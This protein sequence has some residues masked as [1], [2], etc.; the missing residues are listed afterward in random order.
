[1]TEKHFTAVVFDFDGTLLDTLAD[2]SASVNHALS[3]QGL[4]PRT[5]DEV[6]VALGYGYR[7]L[8]EHCVPENTPENV[9]NDTLKIFSE[10]YYNH[11]L[12]YTCPY[13]GIPETLKEL[14]RKGYKMGIVSN[15]NMAAVKELA[16]HFFKGV[17]SVAIGES[18]EVRRKP[19]PD[20]VLTVLKELGATPEESLYVGDSEVDIVTA[21]NAGMECLSVGWGF[22]TAEFLKAHGAT[23]I[24]N[25]PEEIADFVEGRIKA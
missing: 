12:T 25:K 15:K 17:I 16:E 14:Q 11:N 23:T 9:V 5:P 10:Y 13:K 8:I 24:I 4:P 2:L 1:M 20:T 6:R 18:A 19:A 3:E 21:K 7:Y 22:R